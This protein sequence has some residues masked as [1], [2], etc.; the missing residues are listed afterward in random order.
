MSLRALLL[1]LVIALTMVGPLAA[2]VLYVDTLEDRLDG[3][4]DCSLREAVA[5]ANTD[6]AVDGCA[7]G[8][9]NDSIL[10]DVSGTI[11]LAEGEMWVWSNLEII[12]EPPHVIHLRAGSDSRIFRVE[13]NSLPITYFVVSG[14]EL[15]G[16]SPITGD[17]GAILLFGFG[18]TGGGFFQLKDTILHDNRA[19][20]GGAVA[21]V[22]TTAGNYEVRIEDSRFLD[23]HAESTVG[24]LLIDSAGTIPGQVNIRRTLFRRNTSATWAAAIRIYEAD[25]T[26]D[27]VAVV[28]SVAGMDFAVEASSG[29]GANLK[30]LNTT[31][32]RNAAYQYSGLRYAAHAGSSVEMVHDTIFGNRSGTAGGAALSVTGYGSGDAPA[33]TM[34][35]TI[36]TDTVNESDCL[37]LSGTT[38]ASQGFNILGDVSSCTSGVASDL[39]GA[40]PQILEVGDF[41]G[42]TM[43]ALPALTSPAVDSIAAADCLDLNG[44]ALTVD[45]RGTTRPQQARLELPPPDRCDIGAMER[46]PF[47]LQYDDDIF[48]NGFE[49]STTLAWTARSP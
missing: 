38:F 11:D 1:S 46:A 23:N 30:I 14:A 39:V 21:F 16:G 42:N 44:G 32:A 8:N 37:A 45:Q 33:V 4:G 22:P 19:E 40:D 12:V 6:H 24:G 17:G 34:R 18:G 3:D 26:L 31:I 36:L 48:A 49:S 20:N 13:V 5:A 47:E 28:D 43:V 2:A 29:A 25:V 7:A 27:R 35:G 15:S 41:G 10:F 9:L